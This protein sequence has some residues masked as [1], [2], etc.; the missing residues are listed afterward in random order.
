VPNRQTIFYSWQSDTLHACNRTFI[1]EALQ[2]AIDR[3]HANAELI[4]ALRDAVFEVDRDTKGV[5]GSPPITQTILDKIE[6]CSAFV[7]DIT[8]VGKSL[9]KTQRKPARLIPNPNVLIEYGVALK[10]VGHRRIIAVMNT[11]FGQPARENLPFDLRH[12]RWPIT[13]NYSETG[14]CDRNA[15][16]ETLVGEL[17][18]AL[19]EIL[20]SESKL[21]EDVRL[22]TPHQS[23]KDPATFFNSPAE[24]VGDD[25]FGDETPNLT[26]PNEGRAYLR[27]YPSKEIAQLDTELAARTLASRGGLRPMGLDIRGW[28]PA[29]NKFGAIVYDASRDGKLF[30]FT[31]LFLSGEIWGVDAFAV[32]ASHCRQFSPNYGKGYIASLFVERTF[33]LSLANYLQFAKE[34]LHLPL[35][36][37]IRAGLTD[38]KGYPMATEGGFVGR[39]LHNHIE[40]EGVVSSYDRLPH[41]ILRPFFDRVWQQ[42][43]LIRPEKIDRTLAQEFHTAA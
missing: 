13:Y 6:S 39:V 9:R 23:S 32:N 17:A 41:E 4:P 8:F 24:L 11:A 35:P 12:L 16:F 19:I 1:E 3:L 28:T 27:L 43:G 25:V 30:N 20:K 36:L 37:N 33:V 7:A 29:R 22:F 5:S 26:V 14:G 31:Q 10:C 18:D 2:A 42:C 15:I 34:F 21:G 40:W 38:V